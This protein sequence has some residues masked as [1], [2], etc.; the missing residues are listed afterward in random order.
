MDTF[1]FDS[2]EGLPYTGPTV[3][4]LSHSPAGQALLGGGLPMMEGAIVTAP[5][6]SGLGGCAFGGRGEP[7]SGSPRGLDREELRFEGLRFEEL[8]FECEGIGQWASYLAN[9]LIAPLAAEV[10]T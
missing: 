4:A 2:V 1:S 5:Y 6:P 7:K 3:F 9:C 10:H 8:R